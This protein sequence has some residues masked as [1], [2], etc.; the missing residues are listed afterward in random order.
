[1]DLRSDQFYLSFGRT[2]VDRYGIVGHSFGH[3][4][5]EHA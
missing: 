2:V 3:C 5:M 1:M 4:F